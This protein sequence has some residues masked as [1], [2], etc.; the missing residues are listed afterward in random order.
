MNKKLTI[1][2]TALLLGAATSA[3]AASSTELTVTGTITPAGCMPSLSGDGKFDYGNIAAKDLYANNQTRLESKTLQLSV[4]C[5]APTLFAIQPIDNRESSAPAQNTFGL[6]FINGNQRLGYYNMTFTNPAA[7]T[8][9]EKL[10]SFDVGRGW[11]RTGDSPIFRN[12]FYAF[13]SLGTT[14]PH[15]LEEIT[16]DVNVQPW[17]APTKDLTLTNEAQIDGSATLQIVY[18]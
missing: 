11:A 8:P 10:L 7:A 13:G 14:V 1:L 2:G 15:P 16:L 4:N 17:I 6:G 9:L 5:D 12:V 3:F 18:L